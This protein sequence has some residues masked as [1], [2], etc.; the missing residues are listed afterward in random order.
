LATIVVAMVDF[1]I[2]WYFANRGGHREAEIREQEAERIKRSARRDM[3]I[4]SY[5]AN[6]TDSNRQRLEAICQEIEQSDLD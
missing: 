3:A 1:G 5:L 4:L 2:K 6:P